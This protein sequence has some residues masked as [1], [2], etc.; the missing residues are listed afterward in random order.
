MEI[1]E[2]EEGL[3]ASSAAETALASFNVRM[4]A[5]GRRR[6]VGAQGSSLLCEVADDLWPWISEP[7]GDLW[8]FMPFLTNRIPGMM[9]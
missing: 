6:K 5:G 4:N 7:R 9:P 2:A 8:A 1:K 3:E